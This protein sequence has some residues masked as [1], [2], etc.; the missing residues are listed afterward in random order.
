MAHHQK[1]LGARFCGI[2]DFCSFRVELRV[3]VLNVEIKPVAHL[4]VPPATQ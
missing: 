3:I 1:S 4:R 2:G